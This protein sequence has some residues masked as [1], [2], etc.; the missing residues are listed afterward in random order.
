MIFNYTQKVSKFSG[1]CLKIFQPITSDGKNYTSS[2]FESIS[3]SNR[4]QHSGQWAPRLTIINS[5]LWTQPSF[6][7]I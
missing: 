4:D 1:H 5:I 6:L 3:Y 7:P 2:Q